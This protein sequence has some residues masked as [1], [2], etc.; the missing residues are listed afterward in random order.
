MFQGVCVLLF[1]LGDYFPEVSTKNTEFRGVF[2][3]GGKCLSWMY[4]CCNPFCWD[5][6]LGGL[7]WIHC[8]MNYFQDLENLINK[9]PPV[10]PG[11]LYTFKGC[12]DVPSFWNLCWT[13]TK[14]NHEGFFCDGSTVYLQGMHLFKSLFLMCKE[15]DDGYVFIVKQQREVKLLGEA[16]ISN[17]TNRSL[18]Q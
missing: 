12:W 2:F 3:W 11:S 13:Y 10:K 4:I 1:L 8:W 5:F 7:D 16:A 14:T 17:K 15:I 18:S 9:T 6:L